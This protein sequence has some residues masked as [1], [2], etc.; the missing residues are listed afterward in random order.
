MQSSPACSRRL[1]IRAWPSQSFLDVR[2]FAVDFLRAAG[3]FVSLRF[4]QFRGQF[5]LLRFEF[6]DFFFQ[7]VNQLLLRLFFAGTRLALNR[8]EPLLFLAVNFYRWS[9]S[10]NS[11]GLRLRQRRSSRPEVKAARA[12][13]ALVLS[14]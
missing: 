2:E 12:D 14:R 9:A 3:F 7:F 13:D 4:F 8:F 5:N 1:P 11:L 6:L 10:P